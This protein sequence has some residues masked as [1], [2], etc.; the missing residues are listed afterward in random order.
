MVIAIIAILAAML[1]PALA[2]ARDKARSVSCVNNMKQ[3]G[4]ALHMYAE[5]F[6]DY[7]PPA[8]STIPETS[9]GQ[10]LT[11]GKYLETPVEGKPSSLL[12]P[13][14]DPMVFSTFREIYGLWFGDASHGTAWSTGIY[15][16]ITSKIENDRLILADSTRVGYNANWRQAVNLDS[17]DGEIA[18]SKK[19]VHLRHNGFKT[20]NALYVDNHVASVNAG[21]L[22]TDNRYYYTDRQ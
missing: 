5:S 20:A 18:D 14:Y 11:E 22:E 9:W 21:A 13:G 8:V 12:C 19:A 15:C 3:C 16:L 17:K 4:L 6:N 7:L 2:K 1:L 10:I